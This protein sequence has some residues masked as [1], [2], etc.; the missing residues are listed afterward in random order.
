MN[1]G[2]DPTIYSDQEINLSKTAIIYR[3]KEINT[4]DWYQTLDSDY[5]LKTNSNAA[6]EIESVT[7]K[8]TLRLS[9]EKCDHSS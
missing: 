6:G 9:M 2:D 3:G 4:G 1:V 7:I 8:N 5:E